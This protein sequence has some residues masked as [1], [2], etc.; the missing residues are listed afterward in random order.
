MTKSKAF[1]ILALLSSSLLCRAQKDSLIYF[2]PELGLS[3][4]QGEE[5]S[6]VYDFGGKFVIAMSLPVFHN[7]LRVSPQVSINYFG[8][9]YNEG[10]RDNL[11][12]WTLGSNVE[13]NSKAIKKAKVVP[14]LGVFYLIG[15]NFLT[16]R[17][18]YSGDRIDLFSFKGLGAD[19]GLKLILSNQF[20]LNLNFQI[21][22]PKGEIDS[23][24]Q[25][26]IRT[27]F[28]VNNALYEVVEFPPS[29]FSFN[30]F[31]LSIGYNLPLK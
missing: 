6:Q 29:E 31:T 18:D 28:G 9:N 10:V 23:Q 21:V 26:E 5:L 24:I 16:P 8:N 13:L 4:S 19:L 20:F 25:E 14:R 2:A 11:I 3:L 27:E 30:N 22:N 17:K 15:N 7:T 12:F 1:L